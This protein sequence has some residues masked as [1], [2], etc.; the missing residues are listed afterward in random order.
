MVRALFELCWFLGF[1]EVEVECGGKYW[2]TYA[3]VPDLGSILYPY[4]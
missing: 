3:L 2:N 1:L 4:I